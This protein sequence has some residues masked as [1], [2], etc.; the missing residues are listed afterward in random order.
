MGLGVSVTPYGLSHPEGV[1]Q[2]KTIRWF[3]WDY[4]AAVKGAM[5]NDLPRTITPNPK[6]ANA[7]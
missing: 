5:Y 1:Y 7:N 4:S 6:K 2:G 3:F